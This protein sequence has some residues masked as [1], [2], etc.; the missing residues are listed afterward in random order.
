MLFTKA[1][2][3]GL[4]GLMY[5]AQKPNGRVTRLADISKAQKVPEKFLAKIFQVL[6]RKGFVHSHRGT[7]GGFS[8]ARPA[9]SMTLGE[10][11]TAVQGPP[12]VA[13]CF[14]PGHECGLY[15]SCNIRVALEGVQE[16]LNRSL[17]RFTL[18]DLVP[19]GSAVAVG[20]RKG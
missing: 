11:L 18:A 8:L 15:S 7:K 17:A 5:L 2:E 4:F 12:A 14:R 1:G 13:E 3:Y 10:I 9:N 6:V 16:Q 19:R 20:A